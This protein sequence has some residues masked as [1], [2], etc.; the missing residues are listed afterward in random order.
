MEFN[1]LKGNTGE[2]L[3]GLIKIKPDI[4]N[5][6]RGYFYEGWNSKKL[7]QHIEKDLVF[8]QDNISKS[9]KNV[10]RGLHYQLPPTP[11][12]K[13]VRC[14]SGSILDVAVDIRKSSKTFG[15]WTAI[16]LSEENKFQ[17]FI[18]EGFAHGFLSLQDNSIIYYKTS[19]NW[20]K[21]LERTIKWDDEDIKIFWPLKKIKPL[22]SEKDKK[23][24]S[25]KEAIKLE[26]IFV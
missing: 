2:I 4:Y 10:L 19:N 25:L 9:K 6:E 22:I 21:N 18:P 12:S 26:E 23:G 8:K 14:I 20:D 11:Q 16:K 17:L 3:E 5:D 15:K 13:L 7:N 24:I 1:Y